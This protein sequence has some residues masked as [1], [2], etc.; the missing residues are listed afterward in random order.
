MRRLA[1]F[2]C[3]RTMLGETLVRVD[4]TK[5]DT[6]PHVPLGEAAAIVCFEVGMTGPYAP[7]DLGI[8]AET[9]ARLCTVYI[10]SSAD[11]TIR[12]VRQDEL[13]G[14]RFSDG[15]R[16]IVFND[17]RPA[18]EGLFVTRTALRAALETI[19]RARTGGSS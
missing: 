12:V 5:P 6:K 10:G 9:V 14:G 3:Y 17:G 11:E 19:Q 8:M 7:R 18:L 1:Y 13:R 16:R 4:D 2:D 15:G